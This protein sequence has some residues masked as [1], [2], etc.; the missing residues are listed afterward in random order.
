MSLK[1]LFKK[2][3]F[4]QI[5]TK[6]SS[7]D[8]EQEVESAAYIPTYLNKAKKILPQIDYSDPK[9]FARYGSA[10][11]YYQDSIE[12]IYREYPYDGS[13]REKMEW[14]QTSLLIDKY[15]FENHYPRTN[16]YINFLGTGSLGGRAGSF[17]KFTHPYAYNDYAQY[18]FLKGGPH[19]SKIRGEET[20]SGDLKSTGSAN[21]LPNYYDSNTN[22]TSNLEFNGTDGVTVEFWLRKDSYVTGAESPTQVVFD[23]WN[24]GSWTKLT[25][26][27]I[28]ATLTAGTGDYFDSSKTLT[29]DTG[30]V[31][32]L[33][34]V[35]QTINGS[36]TLTAPEPFD[37]N[38]TIV[39][40]SS[41]GWSGGSPG[42]NEIWIKTQSTDDDFSNVM[43]EVINGGPSTES[44]NQIK[45]GTNAQAYS[46]SGVPNLIAYDGNTVGSYRYY[47]LRLA[48]DNPGYGRLRIATC[49]SPIT[50]GSSFYV[51][52]M[53]GSGLNTSGAFDPQPSQLGGETTIALGS[54]V[55]IT[56][57]AWHHYAFSFANTGSNTRAR[58]Y[59]DGALNE[60]VI[61]GS[62][63]SSI[64]GTMIAQ[65]GSLITSPSGS[66]D[67]P[68]SPDYRGYGAL[69]GALDEFR[70]WRKERTSEQI[71]RYWK[72]QIGGGTNTDDIKYYYSGSTAD[73]NAVD[74]GVYYK[75]NEGITQTASV[76][77]MVL[78]YSGRITNGT[79]T[80]YVNTDSTGSALPID[81]RSTSSAIVESSASSAE[82]KDPI[83][84]ERHPDVQ[85]LIE[86]KI[87]EGINHDHSNNASI[88]H[89][90]PAWITEEAEETPALKHLTQ[91]MASYFDELHIMI[92]EVNKIKDVRYTSG[93]LS[94]SNKEMPIAKDLLEGVGFDISE[95]FVDAEIVEKFLQMSNDKTHS[96]SLDDIKNL[97]YKN[98]YNN[99]LTIMK[100]KGT[101]KS[102]RN[103]MHCF[104][105]DQDLIKINTFANNITFAIDDEYYDS[106]VK[107]TFLDFSS[108]DAG[109]ATVYQQTGT[110]AASFVA[111][112]GDYFNSIKTL[113]TDTGSAYML[114]AVGQTPDGGFTLTVPQPY[115]INFTIVEKE[116]GPWAASDPTTNEIWIKEQATDDEF[117]DVMAEVIN[118]GPF[119][120]TPTQI[121]FGANAQAYSGS[122]V[123]NLTAYDGVTLGP[124]RFYSLK[125][126]SHPMLPFLS[127]SNIPTMQQEA[128]GLGSTFESNVLF[129]YIPEPD[130]VQFKGNYP[131]TSS[132]F[133]AHSAR[134]DSPTDT[135]WAHN[136]AGDD[137]AFGVRSVKSVK[138]GRHAHFQ[139]SS[140]LLASGKLETDVFYDVYDNSNWTFAVKIAPTKY[141]QATLDNRTVVTADTYMVEFYGINNIQDIVKNEFH[142]SE[143]VSNAHGRGFMSAAKRLFAGASRTNFTGTV[144]VPSDVK[145]AS[146]KAWMSHLNNEE[147]KAHALDSNNYG[148]SQPANNAFVFQT[149][150]ASPSGSTNVFIPKIKTLAL[151]W[152]FELI[153][154]SNSSGEIE[155]YDITSGSIDNKKDYG[156]LGN[157]INVTNG[158]AGYGFPATTSSFVSVEYLEDSRKQLPEV[159]YS[160]DMISILNF[161]DDNFYRDQKPITFFTSIEKNMY[162]GLTEQILNFF[163]SIRDYGALIGRYEE[164]YRQDYKRLSFLKQIFFERLGNTPDIE[165]FIDYYKWVDQSLGTMIMNLVPASANINKGIKTVIESHALERNKYRNKFPTID[166]KFTEPESSGQLQPNIDFTQ[167]DGGITI[168]DTRMEPY[169]GFHPKP[170]PFLAGPLVL[171]PPSTD[172]DYHILWW[173]NKVDKTKYAKTGNPI[174]DVAR[175]K[176]FKV[177]QSSNQDLQSKPFV[178]S[179]SMTTKQI[180]GGVKMPAGKKGMLAVPSLLHF[181]SN[182]QI[183]VKSTNISD[184]RKVYI[185]EIIPTELLKKKKIIE[186]NI[187]NTPDSYIASG[188]EMLLPFM[189]YSASSE[190]DSG[191]PLGGY[192]SLFNTALP[193]TQIS[194]GNDISNNELESPLQS[195]FTERFVGGRQYKNVGL[196]K[197]DQSNNLDDAY[198]R[199]EGYNLVTT[200]GQITI[201]PVDSV[202]IH[203]ARGT[204]TRLPG[205]KRAVN[206]RNISFYQHSG[207]AISGNL[208]FT[209]PTTTMGNFERNYEVVMT[210][211]RDIN[212]MWFISGSTGGGGANSQ[213]AENFNLTGDLDFALPDRSTGSNKTV[214]AERFSAPGGKEVLSK[215]FL[216][217][218]SETYS[219]YNQLN[220]RNSFVRTRLGASGS[221][222]SLAYG[223]TTG[224]TVSGDAYSQ[225]NFLLASS[226]KTNRN[227][228]RTIFVTGANYG[229]PPINLSVGSGSINDNDNVTHQ[230]PQSDRNYNWITSSML[231]INGAP[232]GFAS[233][234]GYVSSSLG[235]VSDF[236]FLSASEISISSHVVDFVGLNTLINAP[237]LTGSNTVSAAS[238]NTSIAS[239]SSTNLLN[240]LLLHQN[241]PY[242]F[243]SWQQIGNSKSPLVRDMVK[244]NRISTFTAENDFFAKSQYK[245][246]GASGKEKVKH[247][248]STNVRGLSSFTEPPV[249]SRFRPVIHRVTTKDYDGEEA[250]FDIKHTYG[251]NLSK[252][253][254][255]DLNNA[256]ATEQ[257]AAKQ[258]YDKLYEVYTNKD[259]GDENPISG[260]VSLNY[261]EN[262]YPKSNNAYLAKS[263]MRQNYTEQSGTGDNG[264]DRRDHRTFWRDSLHA[265]DRTAGAAVNSQNYTIYNNKNSALSVWPLDAGLADYSSGLTQ[266]GPVLDLTLVPGAVGE[267]VQY[268]YTTPLDGPSGFTSGTGSYGYHYSASAC[269]YRRPYN[270]HF[271]TNPTPENL[272][273]ALPYYTTAFSASKSPWFDSYEDYSEDIRRIAKEYTIIPEFRISDHM[274]FYLNNQDASFIGKN[275]KLF[276]L[277]GAAFTSSAEGEFADFNENF[278]N[279]YS[280][281][282][283]MKYFDVIQDNHVGEKIGKDSRIKMTCRGVKKLLPYNGFYPATRT[284]QLASLM[285][286]SIGPYLSGSNENTNDPS[287]ERLNSMLRWSFAPGIMF[288]SIKSGIAVDFPCFTDRPTGSHDSVYKIGYNTHPSYRMPFESLID[289]TKHVPPTIT[290][291][292][293]FEDTIIT[294]TDVYLAEPTA[295]SSYA[296]FNWM[297]LQ[298]KPNF[299]LAMHNFFAE[300][301]KFFIKDE[302]LTNFFSAPESKFK[303]MKAGEVYDMKVNMYKTNDFIMSEGAHGTGGSGRFRNRGSIYGPPISSTY[304]DSVTTNLRQFDDP[305][306]APYTPPYF[307]GLSQATLTFNALETKK[308]TLAEIFAGLTASYDNTSPGLS[309]TTYSDAASKAAMQL[310]SSMNI[311]G[312]T[313]VKKVNYST[314]LGPSGDFLPISFEDSADSAFDVWSIGT[315]WEC[316]AFNLSGT[317][318]HSKYPCSVWA[319]YGQ[320]P[321]AGS[322]I[323]IGVSNGSNNAL[324]DVVGFTSTTKKI[325]EIAESK[326]ISEAIVAI[327]FV[328]NKKLVSLETTQYIGKSFFKIDK[329]TYDYQIK[330]KNKSGIAVEKA[331]TGDGADN[332]QQTSIT[333]MYEK[334][335]KYVIPPQLD[336]TDG[337]LNTDPFV[338]Y[339]FEFDH[340]LDQQDLSD[341]WQGVMPKIS[342][343]AEKQD[344]TIE[345][346]M[347]KHEFFGGN[348]LPPETRWMVFKVKRR[349]ENNYF[350]ITADSKDDD[351]F[352]FLFKSSEKDFKHSYNWPY[353]FFSL[354][355]LGRIEA[356]VE[357]EGAEKE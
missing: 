274:D 258:V 63:V 107:K 10:A 97:I 110:V 140:S 86:T 96:Q 354:V 163:S 273:F 103:L 200:A 213:Y 99:L 231:D 120:A 329:K 118:G 343:T 312:R 297:D 256:L 221:A 310:S 357:I 308:Y 268:P 280:H 94:D 246:S 193:G 314:G 54:D 78:D 295:T 22:R 17:E 49:V 349:A 242:G 225:S 98:I 53:S 259:L 3:K 292:D 87:K 338:M 215:G 84:Y 250:Q 271:S 90:L 323:K 29:T 160:E 345:H 234:R 302:S 1:D 177:Y 145:I 104:G 119:D 304:A 130:T 152:D 5:L 203:F 16:G 65:I 264:F 224:S 76:D 95:I 306:Y 342:V 275:N 111:G 79:W 346:V 262:I 57:S 216:D 192:L 61:T 46:G 321:G 291:K 168:L 55:P 226:H 154:G 129:P 316:P 116:A 222:H 28:A 75:F 161:D 165:K 282:E 115:N 37:I 149:G 32:I 261:S 71:G 34:A 20:L 348:S 89:S 220:Y 100:S 142:V 336:F 276:S 26:S 9:N 77:S 285:S 4:S 169:E 114:R 254:S 311:F 240:A 155:V 289:V 80:G 245:W 109:A 127:A 183:I 303:T 181:G 249:I 167:N 13:L 190:H 341:I 272:V 339:I 199:A 137:W 170:N 219:V 252:F 126:E 151:D 356:G 27:T 334:M 263:R 320:I 330:L 255:T 138:D 227:S 288:N 244:N 235:E 327:P 19:P 317:V 223:I 25:G 56:S 108:V 70:F 159:L 43:A 11:R 67:V 337:D 139:L 33:R 117:S 101:I 157:V 353:D 146:V 133:G 82:F 182:K 64:T 179:T 21:T 270:Q 85:A 260:L 128:N 241:G 72:R 52:L 210:T 351:R 7:K 88:Y 112:T 331:N 131:L 122:G 340:N 209:N 217:P 172:Q 236:T 266:Y 8:L 319:G 251:N 232:Y 81:M 31:D 141:P 91:I 248:S 332:L 350:K 324:L 238:L 267:L 253:A 173:K 184:M 191:K 135:T 196:N 144:S 162:Q 290:F 45:F 113:T 58:L 228:R 284:A 194:F 355:E 189:L 134:P 24:S 281:S 188:S 175:Q 326:N 298:K 44:N 318:D 156:W 186:V 283:F 38:F 51:T 41:F 158:A 47:S 176:L 60:E 59:V 305:A 333:D 148:V 269:F 178:F 335:Q 239:L 309:Q 66:P 42:S 150:S 296:Y 278:F 23:L 243:V 18:I 136:A 68:L 121:K 197:P 207:S 125:L 229:L 15:I 185:E 123:P 50:S 14:D 205:A 237:L 39:E 180:G 174:V 214:I 36:F 102:L 132:I 286:Q 287:S 164:R 40:K 344:V 74:L 106:T 247:N 153:T 30:S 257:N 307:Y 166:S 313:R 83:I 315:K 147:I 198:S 211:G 35:G 328:D 62:S 299:E 201:V 48:T 352:Q 279:T 301:V 293:N 218:A 202:N 347:D 187:E 206:I 265:R 294:Q 92:S 195:V 12:R 230:I 233:S 105:V 277:D 6:K 325:S 204:R 69:S 143:S 208:N 124:Y 2:D 73:G 300:S 322:G 171:S 93:S 212:N